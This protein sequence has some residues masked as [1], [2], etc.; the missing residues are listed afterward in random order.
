M[1]STTVDGPAGTEEHPAPGAG[2]GPSHPPK[3]A[4]A[5]LRELRRPVAGLTRA[6]VLL[7]GLGAL[8]TLVPFIG[9]AELAKELLR[10]DGVDGGRAAG[11]VV[12]IVLGLALGWTCTGVALWLTHVADSRLQALLRRRM[13]DRLGG[14]GL[15]WYS[16]TTSGQVRKAAQ[17]DLNDLHHLVAHHD[18]EAAA[19]VVLPLGGLT[20]LFWLD[21]RLGLLAMATLPLYALAY[22]WMMRG[23]GDKLQQMD[24]AF[25]RVS[26]AIVEFVHGIAVVKSFGTTGRAH[27]AYR[28]AT[29]SFGRRYEGWVRPMLRLEA[30][31]SMA[32]SAPVIAVVSLAGGIWFVERGWVGPIDVLA[33]VLV[34]LI[35]PT[36][37]QT[38]NEGFT[39]RGA[40][41]AAAE[42]ITSLLATPVLP[43][44]E[45]PVH[46]RGHLVEFDDVTFGYG[47]PDG[48]VGPDGSDGPDGGSGASR[49]SGEPDGVAVRGVSLT[50][51]PGTVTALVGPSGAGKST[52]AKLLLR[53]HDVTDGAIRVGGADLR[54]IAPEEL[55][56]TVGFV[57]QDVQLLHGT[58]AENLRLGRPDATDEELLAAATAAQIHERI[59]ELPR[60]YDS[61]IGE[62]A[63]FSGGEAQRLAIARA[64]LA[65]TPVLV[66]DEATA[67]ADPESEARI[68]DALSAVATGRTVLVIAHR[69]STIVGVDRIAVLE[70]GRLVETGTHRELIAGGGTYARMWDAY[71]GDTSGAEAPGA[72]AP[73]D[74]APED[75]THANTAPGTDSGR[76][77]RSEA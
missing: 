27:H 24:T 56:R 29:H 3:D 8:T 68:Q 25:G 39:A 47:S 14:V 76:P 77:E 63:R 55:Y 61:V 71:G 45:R 1:T 28:E 65:D 4:Q 18:V 5:A 21:W 32:L 69:L 22:G 13:V 72:E 43:V 70:G 59:T 23:I 52:L 40:A 33:Q 19:A 66:L 7:G 48:E 49:A 38:V 6:G 31:T 11:I 64:L 54:D 12:V 60:G 58:V 44:A 42:R 75:G 35:I 53:F 41:R 10:A 57:L 50:C 46:P 2:G 74:E 67:F 9:I 34:A 51:R 36:T 30:S 15:G 20:Y 16:A 73:G 17:N 26:A 62:E 37:L